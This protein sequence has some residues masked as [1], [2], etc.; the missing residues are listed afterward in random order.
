MR[1][2]S[3]V[4][5][6]KDMREILEERRR[7]RDGKR[8]PAA[9]L[10]DARPKLAAPQPVVEPEPMV[11]KIMMLPPGSAY[12]CLCL[13][14]EHMPGCTTPNVTHFHDT[15]NAFLSSCSSV[16]PCR[17]MGSCWAFLDL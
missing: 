9:T 1:A 11:K 6:P 16:P 15:G 8:A 2:D 4:M 17:T 5:Q 10:A 14:P 3:G 7:A 12:L 13:V